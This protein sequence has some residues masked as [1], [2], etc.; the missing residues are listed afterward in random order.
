MSMA[1]DEMKDSIS[2]AKSKTA[3]DSYFTNGQNRW[4]SIEKSKD[5]ELP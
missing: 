5:T 4:G 3:S 1:I 2:S